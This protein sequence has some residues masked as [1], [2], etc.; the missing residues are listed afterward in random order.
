MTNPNPDEKLNIV[1]C[2]LVRN[3]VKYPDNVIST[4]P[5]IQEAQQA[6]LSNFVSKEAAKDRERA[7]EVNE[8]GKWVGF[9]EVLAI[10]PEIDKNQIIQSWLSAE[11]TRLKALS[12]PQVKEVGDE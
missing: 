5:S 6:I 10:K 11:R 4:E 9:L 8:L 3:H 12:A 7:A 1:L 2:E